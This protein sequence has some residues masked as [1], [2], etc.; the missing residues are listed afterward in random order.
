[1]KQI[2]LSVKEHRLTNRYNPT[3]KRYDY[4]KAF[5]FENDA[6]YIISLFN[7]AEPKKVMEGGADLFKLAKEYN[8]Y[9]DLEKE[10]A[11]KKKS[12][13]AEMLTIIGDSDKVTHPGFTIS[14]GMDKRG[15]RTFRVNWKGE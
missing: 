15:F 14:C 5:D 8:N 10:N 9:N 4:I 1:M 7:Y 3:F 6:D 2:R 12:A 11:N 13:K